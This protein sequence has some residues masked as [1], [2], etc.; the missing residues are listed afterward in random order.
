VDVICEMLGVPETD[1]YLFPPWARDLAARVDLEPLRTPEINRRGDEAARDLTAYLDGLIGDAS[2]RTPGGLLDALVAA[3]QDGD[4]LTRDEVITT[5]GLLL[6]AGHETTA[7]LIANGVLAL[8]R[9]PDALADLRSGDVPVERAVEELL[10]HD[11]P[12]QMVQRVALE[13]LDVRG[14]TVTRGDLIVLLLAAANRDPNVFHDPERLD[15]DRDPNPHLAFSSGIHAC[16]GASLARMETA[17]VLRQLLDRL[18]G[19]RLDGVPRW[20]DTFV[21][22][23]LRS[24]PLAWGE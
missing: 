12:V 1:R 7:N 6:M 11:G 10:R 15:L 19:L 17:V 24:L 20:R 22:R 9:Q 23:G 4:A 18:P 8:L 2:R 16:L 5:C 14:A 3:G 21:L 13:D